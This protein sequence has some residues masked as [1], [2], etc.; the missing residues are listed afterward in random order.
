MWVEFSV[1][2]TF[3]ATSDQDNLNNS[4]RLS[5]NETCLALSA[6]WFKKYVCHALG[7]VSYCQVPKVVESGE[8]EWLGKTPVVISDEEEKRNV[9]QENG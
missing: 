2:E 3:C 5:R 6:D 9:T 7:G 4:V 1:E 8:I